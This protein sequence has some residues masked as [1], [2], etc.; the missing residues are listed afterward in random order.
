M[1]VT[2]EGIQSNPENK[3]QP[4]AAIVF[5]KDEPLQLAALMTVA[6]LPKTGVDAGTFLMGNFPNIVSNLQSIQNGDM[7]T[8]DA[9]PAANFNR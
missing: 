1:T 8:Q 9:T 4:A 3:T 5:A 2:N 7:I 6:A